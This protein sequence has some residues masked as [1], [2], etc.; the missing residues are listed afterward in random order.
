MK[1]YTSLFVTVFLLLGSCAYSQGLQN[2]VLTAKANAT[3]G[4]DI[5]AKNISSSTISGPIGLGGLT[6][7]VLVPASVSPQPTVSIATTVTSL[8]FGPVVST[9]ETTTINSASYYVY[10]FNGATLSATVNFAPNTEVLIATY[11]FTGIPLQTSNVLLA[12]LAAGGPT[13]SDYCYIAPGGTDETDYSNPFYSDIASDPGLHNAN[14][15]NDPSVNGLSYLA[16]AGVTLPVKF[17]GF[18]ATKSNDNALL[19]WAVSNEGPTTDHYEIERSFDGVDFKDVAS[20][21]VKGNGT[22]TSNN[23]SYTDDNISSLNSNGVIYYRVEQVDKNGNVS[24]T[25]IQAVRLTNSLVISAYPN[26][27]K[28]VVSLTLNLPDAASISLDLSDAHGQHL[29]K[30]EIAG[31]KG[32]NFSSL[33]MSG[34]ASGSYLLKVNSGGEVSTIK[35]IKE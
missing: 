25:S 11:N 21:S 15:A 3:N 23:Y 35:L 10:T 28:D 13:Q 7:C 2:I 14:G 16:V 9:T 12:M 24:Y 6:L 33:N 19:N 18:S 26:P 34:Y 8:T 27:V 5:Y 31:S 20:V 1:K 17:T 4:L 29:Q 22:L 32:A 30:L